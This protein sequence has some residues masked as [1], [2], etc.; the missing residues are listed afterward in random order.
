MVAFD[1][2]KR[3]LLLVQKGAEWVQEREV[4]YGGI[5]GMGLLTKYLD[6]GSARLADKTPIFEEGKAAPETKA[7]KAAPAPKASPATLD[8]VAATAKEAPPVPAKRAPKAKA[9]VAPVA[10]KVEAPVAPPA[11]V[12]PVLDPVI[13]HHL[14]HDRAVEVATTTDLA[15]L[16]KTREAAI[17]AGA[18]VEVVRAIT[19]RA[20]VIA[21]GF[22]LAGVKKAPVAKVATE[23]A[24]RAERAEKAPM[25]VRPETVAKLE[26]AIAKAGVRKDDGTVTIAAADLVTNGCSASWA[27]YPEDWRASY[28]AG[29]SAAALGFTAKL[30]KT[31]SGF[32]LHLTPVA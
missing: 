29:R 8:T 6:E 14:G 7:P 24:P 27:K 28:P 30:H 32:V 11:P 9:P 23:K 21:C 20:G 2:S 1:G 15:V 3:T 5:R 22:T 17:T 13:V 16:R 18:P 12:G 25:N 31:E 4:Q 26:N 10:P 19:L